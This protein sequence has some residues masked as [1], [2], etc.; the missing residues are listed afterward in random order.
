MS[1]HIYSS[2]NVPFGEILAV[3]LYLPGAISANRA[4]ALECVSHMAQWGSLQQGSSGNHNSVP[5]P[6]NRS[7]SVGPELA[8]AYKQ[9]FTL[10]KRILGS[11]A[12]HETPLFLMNAFL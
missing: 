4:G 7:A 6:A 10:H 3:H 12:L 1:Q 8:H 5:M 9:H 2:H 11:F